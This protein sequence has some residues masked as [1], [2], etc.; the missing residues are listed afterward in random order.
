[1]KMKS[2]DI[3]KIGNGL[4]SIVNVYVKFTSPNLSKKNSKLIA[5]LA[6][7]YNTDESSLLA[8]EKLFLRRNTIFGKLSS[9]IV[10]FKTAMAADENNKGLKLPTNPM[11]G[12][13]E[14]PADQLMRKL[15]IRDKFIGP[16]G[17]F[18]VL[19]ERLRGIF[20]E[21]KAASKE[22]LGKLG[23]EHDWDSFTEEKFVDKYTLKM[24]WVQSTYALKTSRDL[25]V[26][27]E[28]ADIATANQHDAMV[29]L[30]KGSISN[31]LSSMTDE[32]KKSLA[33]VREGDR[34]GQ[35]AFDR[36]GR[37][38]NALNSK[39]KSFFNKGDITELDDLLDQFNA[40]GKIKRENIGTKFQRSK[41]A[42][43]IESVLNEHDDLMEQLGL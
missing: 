43:R 25:A 28:V 40:L 41:T 22:R 10:K 34:F 39:A 15:E 7:K 24:H 17:E 19:K 38:Y 5:E 32:L 23:E 8:S 11:T 2:F 36:F 35:L 33:Q 4:S 9:T 30:A 29:D 6:D 12:A 1:M 26:A 16:E 27:Q 20:S 37:A 18:T 21:L 14:V 31:L 3:E 42:D 13:I